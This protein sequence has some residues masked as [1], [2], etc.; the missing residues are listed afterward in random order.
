MLAEKVSVPKKYIDFLDIFFKKSVAVF[1]KRSDINKHIIEL[2]LSK[3]LFYKL[4]YSLD[5]V[6]LKIFKIYIETIIELTR[7]LG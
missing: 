7:L 6:E 2:K 3:Q 5:P 4:I 1:S